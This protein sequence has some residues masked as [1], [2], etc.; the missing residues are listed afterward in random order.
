MAVQERGNANRPSNV[1]LTFPQDMRLPR[2]GCTVHR[3]EAE[4]Q[5]HAQECAGPWEEARADRFCLSG[6]EGQEVTLL[7]KLQLPD[8][9]RPSVVSSSFGVVCM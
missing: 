6:G 8:Q 5:G 1:L 9:R 2:H 4:G 7:P 3:H